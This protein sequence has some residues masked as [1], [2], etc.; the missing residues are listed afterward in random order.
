MFFPSGGVPRNIDDK[1]RLMVPPEYREV[2][3]ASCPL[4]DNAPFFWLTISSYGPLVAYL[5]ENWDI[6]VNKLCSI[7]SV[8]VKISHFKSKVLGLAEKLVIDQQ[9][10]VRVSQQLLRAAGLNKEVM[11]VGVGDKFEIW[12]KKVYDELEAED[13][14]AEL[15]AHGVTIPL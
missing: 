15:A 2:L 7:Q 9:G 10:R 11:M 8:S 6:I 4:P 12:D 14:S 13:I 3:A 1:G 5:P